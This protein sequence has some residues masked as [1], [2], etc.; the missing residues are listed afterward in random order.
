MCCVG[1]VIYVVLFV[2][3]SMVSVFVVVWWFVC[4]GNSV[5]CVVCVLS[6][7]VSWLNWFCIVLM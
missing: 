6:L 1:L 5:V 2:N 4:F 3:S 7:V